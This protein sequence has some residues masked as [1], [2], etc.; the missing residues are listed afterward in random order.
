MA[1]TDSSDGV[2]ETCARAYDRALDA[3]GQWLRQWQRTKSPRAL[4]ATLVCKRIAAEKFAA[5]RAELQMQRSARQIMRVA[6]AELG[7]DQM[8]YK[9]RRDERAFKQTPPHVVAPN[10]MRSE[11]D[12][13]TDDLAEALAA[14]P[15][16]AMRGGAF[17]GR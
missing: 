9:I 4:H 1:S 7:L 11:R 12:L 13:E 2:Q 15:F 3:W 10:A 8:L 6:R 16:P 14:E 5:W 17:H